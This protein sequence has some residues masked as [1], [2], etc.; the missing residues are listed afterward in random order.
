MTGARQAND[1]SFNC[2]GLGRVEAALCRHQ[3]SL[4]GPPNT[5]I[6]MTGNSS[7]FLDSLRFLQAFQFS[8]IIM[9]KA[10]KRKNPIVDVVPANTS[11]AS[12]AAQSC[13]TTIRRYHVLLKQQRNLE[14]SNDPSR[15]LALA[16]IKRE[17]EKLGGL[18]RY[19]ELS[20][21]GQREERGG[22]S[23]KVLISWMKDLDFH[24]LHK[25]KGKLR[26][27]CTFREMYEVLI[28]HR[29]LEV[30]ALKPDNYKSCSTWIDWTPIDL[31]SRH[32]QIQEQDFLKMSLKEHRQKWNAISLSLVLNFVPV[33]NDRGMRVT[34]CH[35]SRIWDIIV[36]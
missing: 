2:Q 22:G 33:P 11:S 4:P 34:P 8:V 17:L 10:R 31:H 7:L 1:I 28:C 26:C 29:L 23:E 19:Q 21:L 3:V 16:E 35:L 24:T 13:R 15:T 12:T 5:E 25:G 30:G 9:P 36:D 18:E 6:L 20:S 27:V 14:N 32:P